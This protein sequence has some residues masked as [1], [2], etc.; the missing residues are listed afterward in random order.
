MY[1]N[2][3]VRLATSYYSDDARQ[4]A[5]ITHG[6]HA[7]R[8]TTRHIG[9]AVSRGIPLRVGIIDVQDG[10]HSEE[11]ARVL[12]AM[13]VKTIGF[14]HLR[15][16]GRGVRAGQEG[17]GQLCGGCTSGV[18]AI[19]P[20]GMVNPCVFTEFMPVGNV[21]LKPL[22]EILAGRPYANAHAR[23]TAEF[24]GRPALVEASGSGRCNPWCAP[25][26]FPATGV[27][28]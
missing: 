19:S 16:V 17:V 25:N 22:A 1:A 6:I 21:R 24:A 8:L 12:R 18:I 9:Q 26:C 14:D 10:Q 2:P 4:H 3:Q 5:E 15:G 13:G 20:D 23:L 28:E 11:A 7:H 27:T